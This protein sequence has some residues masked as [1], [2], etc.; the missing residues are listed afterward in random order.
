MFGQVG[1][2]V[3]REPIMHVIGILG[4][5]ASGKSLVTQQLKQLGAEAL[6]ADRAGHEVLR[7]AEVKKAIR[8]HF[9]D[10]VF[11]INGEV[12]RP[13][14]AKIVFAPPPRG[15]QELTELEKI[16][17]PRIADRL[18]KSIEEYSRRGDLPALVL[19]APVLL[20][21]GWDKFCDRLLFVD[22]TREQ[23]VARAALRGWT[24]A[25]L[26]AREAAQESLQEKR[27]HA[28]GIIDNS[29]STER[30]FEQVRQFW[31]TLP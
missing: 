29:G 14:L 24:E 9:G 22:A 21:A 20:K 1:K 12:S 28:D 23:R 26:A 7:E 15:P 6:D 25:D 5:V 30:T 17:H 19:D 8:N 31:Q 3:P 11:D 27:Q 16:T 10:A 2:P 13:S 4:G 18:Q